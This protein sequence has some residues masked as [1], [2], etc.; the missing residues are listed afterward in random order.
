[1]VDVPQLVLQLVG[2][3]PQ[4]CCASY[5]VTSDSWVRRNYLRVVGCKLI[6]VVARDEVLSSFS[7]TG[8]RKIAKIG[9]AICFAKFAVI[10]NLHNGTESRVCSVVLAQVV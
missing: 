1:M 5:S 3:S 10:V 8:W 9:A 2:G 7:R 6:L 4:L